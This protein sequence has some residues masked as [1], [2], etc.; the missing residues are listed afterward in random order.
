MTFSTIPH[1]NFVLISSL[2]PT[3]SKPQQPTEN[4]SVEFE[5][6]VIELRQD[7]MVVNIIYIPLAATHDSMDQSPWATSGT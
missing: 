4:T 3:C 5:A 2:T 7:V 6:K 1:H